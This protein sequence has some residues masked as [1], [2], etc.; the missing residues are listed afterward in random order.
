MLTPTLNQNDIING[1]IGGKSVLALSHQYKT[2]THVINKILKNNGILKISQ[3]KRLN[4]SLKEN[5]FEQINDKN[6]AYWLGLILTDG[7]VNYSNDNLQISLVKEDEYILYLFEQDLGIE[8]HVKPFCEKYSRFSFGSKIMLQ[9][10]I[11]YGIIP[12]KTL[13]LKFPE[14]IPE[15]FE[16]HLLRGMFDGDGGFTL[17]TTTRFYKHRN[18]SYTK[19]YQELSFTGT[20][21][22]C[23]GFQNILLKHIDIPKKNITPNHSIYRIRWSNKEEIIQILNL[24]YQDCDNHYLKRKYKLYQKLKEGDCHD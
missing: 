22:M 23:K 1:Y 3:A 24:L 16:T 7:T 19:P 8:N 2:N 4:P 9:D 18:K 12:N 13:T 11:Q 5:Y 15:K 17:G 10:L 6:K 14:N 21:E 20:Y